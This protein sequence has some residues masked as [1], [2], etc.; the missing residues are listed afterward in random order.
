MLT[1]F[2]ACAQKLSRTV[3]DLRT[4]DEQLG[5]KKATNLWSDWFAFEC[6]QGRFGFALCGCCALLPYETRPDHHIFYLSALRCC[7]G[8]PVGPRCDLPETGWQIEIVHLYVHDNEAYFTDSAVQRCETVFLKIVSLLKCVPEEMKSDGWWM[9]HCGRAVCDTKCRNI[10]LRRMKRECLTA[11][12]TS[13][14]WLR[15]KKRLTFGVRSLLWI[16][17]ENSRRAKRHIEY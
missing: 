3:A 7:L 2:R 14:Y 16:K 10:S 5:M 13:R 8:C 12:W 17:G 11:L 4:F 9:P 6:F 15:L 1:A